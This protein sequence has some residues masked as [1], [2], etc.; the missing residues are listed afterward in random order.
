MLRHPADSDR[1]RAWLEL[2]ATFVLHSAR[3]DMAF[4]EASGYGIPDPS[5]WEDT[6]LLAHVAGETLPGQTALAR[7]QAKLIKLGELPADALEPEDRIRAWLASQRKAAHTT[8]ARPPQ[9]GDAPAE[10]LRPYL[11]ADVVATR[12]VHRHYAAAL[13]GQ[14]AVYALE[15]RLAPAVY[16]T[17]HRGVPIDLDA[18]RELRDRLEISIGDLQ[19]ELFELVGGPFNLNAARQLERILLERGV[20]LS[21]VPRTPR[22]AQPMFT[23]QTLATLDDELARTLLA[24]RGEKKMSDYVVG[25]WAH[26][27]GDRLFG[28][29]RQVG[30]QTG[31]MSSSRP[32]LQNLPRSDLRVRYAV[33]A[34]EG[35]TLVGADLDSV[36][37][38]VLAC[39]ARG[40]ALERAFAEGVDLHQQTADA[41][42]VDRDAGKT[43]NY[44]IL[45]G[46]GGPRISR[47]LGCSIAEA[48]A[49]L[50]GWYQTYPEVARLKRRLDRRVGE[51]GYLESIGGRRHN[52]E[53]PNHMLLNRLISGG[54]ADLFKLTAIELHELDVP[55]VLYVHDEIIAEV[56]EEQAEETG[57]TLERALTRGVPRITGLKATATAARRWSDFKQP[58]YTP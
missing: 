6:V 3:F 18:A 33:C 31:R 26:T 44:A 50:D 35:M 15:R 52:F 27:H 58:G 32:N 53:R 9:R 38:R 47:S 25:L 46:A 2:D 57:R 28:E 12:A 41:L 1:I 56:P 42:G 21:A 54:C 17:E 5:R 48:R 39:Y 55:V 10:V 49:I 16:A 4:L 14:E 30:S 36:E 24:W 37:L 22:T 43:L 45:Y 51:R 40:G 8:G 7:L 11:E 23:A 29:F 19:S 34:G 20:D 13:N